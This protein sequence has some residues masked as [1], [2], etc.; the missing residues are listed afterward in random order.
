ME[1]HG[2]TSVVP[3]IARLR[4]AAASVRFIGFHLGVAISK[5]FPGL[6]SGV[7]GGDG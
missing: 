5:F 3:F 1:P 7:S 4:Y 6:T 2:L